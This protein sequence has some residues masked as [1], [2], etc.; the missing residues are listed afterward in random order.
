M[1]HNVFNEDLLT[2]YKEPQYKGQH[3]KLAPLPDII[4]EEKEYKVEE[5]RKHWK[6]EQGTQYLVH[7]KGYGNEHD[8]WIAETGFSHAKGAIEDY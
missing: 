8:Q 6:K 2:Q 5:I 3:V 4:T 7:W 1:I